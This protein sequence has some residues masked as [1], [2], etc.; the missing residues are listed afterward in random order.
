MVAMAAR[1]LVM[2]CAAAGLVACGPDTPGGRAAAQELTR[3]AEMAQQVPPE[4]T[5]VPVP[6]EPPWQPTAA[7]RAELVQVIDNDLRKNPALT[8][9]QRHDFAEQ[10][11]DEFITAGQEM[12]VEEARNR[13]VEKMLNEKYGT[14]A[15]M[16]AKVCN[17][18]R[19]SVAALQGRIEGKSTDM[20]TAGER[21][22]LP[23]ILREQQARV[24]DACA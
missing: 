5:P 18:L 6:P 20:L 2:A 1:C 13:A 10:F 4:P 16:R 7:E 12:Q 17:D 19:V 24:A 9:Q 11:A 22:Q 23:G 21:A 3:K 8:D 14:P 15:E